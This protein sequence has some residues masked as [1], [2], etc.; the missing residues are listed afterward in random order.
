MLVK[1]DSFDLARVKNMVSDIKKGYEKVVVS[2]INKTVKTTKVQSK[3]RIG[4]ELNLP[5]KRIDKNLTIKKASY[6]KL[7]GAVVSS[8]TPV[9][10]IQFAPIQKESGISVKVLRSGTR[11]IVNHAFLAKGR[12]ESGTK[13]MYMREYNWKGGAPGIKF[14][15]GKRYPNVAWGRMPGKYSYKVQRLTGPRIEDIFAKQQV[16]GPITIQ[17]NKLLAD[18]ANKQIGE[19]IRRHNL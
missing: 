6:S 2:S 19:I 17:A 10:L 18:T 12:G 7:S 15:R 4:N 13:H 8:G 11:K 3:A 14:A 16:L 1:I 5:A 9:G